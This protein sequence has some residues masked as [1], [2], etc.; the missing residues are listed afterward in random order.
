MRVMTDGSQWACT[1]PGDVQFH[2][3]HEVSHLRRES[4]DLIVAQAEFPEVQ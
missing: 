4:L 2:Q 1:V 3:L